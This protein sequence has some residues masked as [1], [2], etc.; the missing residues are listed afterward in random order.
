MPYLTELAEVSVPFKK[1]S[2]KPDIY[3]HLR[4]FAES[5][6]RVKPTLHWAKFEITDR[7]RRRHKGRKRDQQRFSEK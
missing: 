6:Y 4:I 7:K 5:P 3:T 2:Y 1:V